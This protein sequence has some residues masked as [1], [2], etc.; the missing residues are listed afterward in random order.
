MP[1]LP[2]PFN[3]VA[4]AGFTERGGQRDAGFGHENGF[5]LCLGNIGFLEPVRPE[6]LRCGQVR[7][8]GSPGR[9]RFGAEELLGFVQPRL[10]KRN[11]FAADARQLVKFEVKR[12]GG[13]NA[14]REIALSD[15]ADYQPAALLDCLRRNLSP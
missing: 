8:R 10:K 7:P 5:P 15:D 13:R 1:E 4:M 9:F 3:S 2:S 12:R 14:V 11:G 6:F